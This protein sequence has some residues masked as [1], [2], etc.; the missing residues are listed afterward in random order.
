MRQGGKDTHFLTGFGKALLYARIALHV[1]LRYAT[2]PA[3]FAYNPLRYFH[4]LGRALCLLLVFRHNKVVRVRGGWKLHLYLPAWP[5]EAF[6]RAVESKLLR[7]P[8]GPVT[9]VYS[10]TKACAYHCAHCYQRR[11]GGADLPEATL[12]ALARAVREAG[13]SMFDIEGGE[14]FLRFERLLALV[15]ELGPGV[16]VWVNT[17]GADLKDGMLEALRDAG[18]CGLMVSIHSPDAAT[19]D[20]L[21][22]I[23]GSFA[24]ACAAIRACRALGLAAA[25]NSVLAEDELR[26][27]RLGDLMLL[28][29]ELDC[30]FVQ[31]IHP[32]AAGLWLGRE[33]GMQRDAALIEAIR[34]QHLLYNSRRRADFPALAAQVFEEAP[35]VLGC[36]AGAV[37][38]F[39]VNAHGEVQPCEFLNVSFGNAATEPFPEILAR[40]RAAFPEPG[41]DWLC[42]TQA[43]SI[44]GAIA[45]QGGQTPLPWPA[46]RDLVQTW[47][48]GEPTPIYRRLGIYRP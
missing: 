25:A 13:T 28:A 35:R 45:A 3:A 44:A 40:M 22:G 43:A 39:Y 19:H 6:F 30:D 32:K 12:L 36:T 33:E 8:P 27:G 14:P 11:D 42:C 34:R 41:V 20:A 15:R 10:M 37:D 23:A 24:T 48:R 2:R 21:T 31:L 29:R 46:T 38:R 9:V 17:T 26:A 5:G 1:T 16:E 18:L 4:F 47:R 7:R